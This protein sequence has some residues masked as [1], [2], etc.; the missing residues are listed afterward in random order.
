MIKMVGEVA[1]GAVKVETVAEEGGR[2]W[3]SLR[4]PDE[5]GKA[6]EE[7]ITARMK[8]QKRDTTRTAAVFH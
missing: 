7:D 5:R 8:F 6:T 3:V 4:L 1:Q 2:Q